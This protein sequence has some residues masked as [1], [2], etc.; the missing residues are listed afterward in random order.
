MAEPVEA[1]P[2]DV[3][4]VYIG[5]DPPVEKPS[6]FSSTVDKVLNS[7]F[8]DDD[9][10]YQL[11]PEK[12][13][14]EGL[15]SAGNITKANPYPEGSEDW[16]WYEGK[17]QEGMVPAA[18]AISS[19][20][21]TGGLAGTTD[22][23][24]GATPFLR[25]ALKYKDKL[26]KGKEGQQHQDV[27]PEALYPEFQQMAMS[28]EDISH[29]NFG[30]VN[31]KG[32]FLDR[33]KA[34]R[35]AIDT[36]MVDKFAG[37]YG[38]LTS[39]LLA[40][41]SKPGTA[42]EAMAKTGGVDPIHFKSTDAAT[43]RLGQLQRD[44]AATKKAGGDVDS[45]D[46]MFF[47]TQ[48]RAL[49]NFIKNP[50]KSIIGK[51]RQELERMSI[52]DL[53]RAAYGYAEG[54]KATI[55]PKD[56]NIIYKDDLLNPQDKFKKGGMDWAKSVDRSDPVKVSMSQDGKITLEDG[57]H[58]WFAAEKLNEPLKVEFERIKGK[59]IEKILNSELH[60]KL[61]KTQYK[62]TPVDHEPE[63]K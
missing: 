15:T 9:K 47:N 48:I 29:Y 41:S 55:H 44:K 34:L 63:F 3:K 27:I 22:A 25:P 37:Q 54:D 23:T 20:A 19:L 32:H 12:V 57:H 6:S 45:S 46:Y 53:D 60:Q 49:K 33:E 14:N 52:D 38:A 13:V 11:W 40:D 31:D 4:R 30:F 51:S 62:F 42:I 1:I 61:S 7:L 2:A 5:G 21:G 8:R 50:E 24:L 17:R 35:Y 36:G 16:E 28:G 58:R 43:F 59:P 10:R 18:M 56:I 39:T 26:Y